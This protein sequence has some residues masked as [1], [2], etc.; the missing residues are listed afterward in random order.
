[1]TYRHAT[2]AVLSAVAAAVV[3][4]PVALKAAEKPR[5]A[6]ELG[7]PVCDNAV[8]Q[9]G[10]KVPVWGWAKPGD[11]ITVRLASVTVKGKTDDS[12]VWRVALPPQKA[13]GP[14]ELRISGIK[15]SLVFRNVMVGEVWICSGQSNMQWGVNA[16]A[17]AGAEI[18][19]VVVGMPGGRV[20]VED[21]GHHTG[22]D[23]LAFGQFP[24]GQ[25]VD[26]HVSG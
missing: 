24:L 25:A 20:E 16:S 17:D 10:M 15:H 19:V 26:D 3:L 21:V 22:L 11:Q 18:A 7:A 1:M 12:G 9:R 8:L 2:I 5:P 4:S 6:I 23:P 13:G 14:H